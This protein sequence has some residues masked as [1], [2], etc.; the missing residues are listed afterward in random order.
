[1]SWGERSCTHYGRCNYGS[2]MDS[3]NVDCPY[4]DL[5]PSIENRNIPAGVSAGFSNQTG[6]NNIVIGYLALKANKW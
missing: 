4:Y 6:Y 5:D 1:M 3:C 2:T